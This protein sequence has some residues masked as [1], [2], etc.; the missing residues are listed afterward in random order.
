MAL[1]VDARRAKRDRRTALMLFEVIKKD[2]YIGGYSILTDYI[3]HW[4]HDLKLVNKSAFVPLK[5][6]L[7][8]AFQF[9]WSEECL[10]IDGIH[11]KIQAAHTRLCASRAFFFPVIQ[12]KPKKC[13]MT[14]IPEPLLRWVGLQTWYLRQYENSCRQGDQKKWSCR[15]CAFFRYDSTLFV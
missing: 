13:S 12:P 11:R 5:F 14:L 9:D 2:G 7:G 15:Q 10:M 1:E 8:E 4:R 3:R 6:Q